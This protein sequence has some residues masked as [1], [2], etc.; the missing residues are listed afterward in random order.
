[1]GTG[2][3]R[4]PRNVQKEIFVRFD[5]TV[6][7][8]CCI[9]TCGRLYMWVKSSRLC[10]INARLSSLPIVRLAISKICLHL[11]PVSLGKVGPTVRTKCSCLS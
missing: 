8:V 6:K 1:M 4:S 11:L 3:S 9:S 2:A 10:V 7:K 5:D